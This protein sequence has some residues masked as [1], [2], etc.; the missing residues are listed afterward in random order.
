MG[1]VGTTAYLDKK[2]EWR[3]AKIRW[4]GG[5]VAGALLGNCATV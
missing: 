5:R 3:L 1:S 4:Y 2:K